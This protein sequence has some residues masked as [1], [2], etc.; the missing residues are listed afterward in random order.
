M[1]LHRVKRGIYL[2][3]EVLTS[4]N[5]KRVTPVKY[6]MALNNDCSAAYLSSDSQESF[7]MVLKEQAGGPGTV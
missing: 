6:P 7:S 4:I 2:P 3:F 5:T 1:S